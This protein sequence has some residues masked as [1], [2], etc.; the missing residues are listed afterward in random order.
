MRLSATAVALLCLA[1]TAGLAA[2]AQ[3]AQ[4]VDPAATSSAPATASSTASTWTV[5]WGVVEDLPVPADYGGDSRT[6][7]AVFRPSTGTWWIR[8]IRTVQYGRGGDIPVPADYNGDGKAEIAVVRWGGT[9]PDSPL[10]WYI[11]GVGAYSYGRGTDLPVPANYRGDRRAELAVVRP[12]QGIA[13]NTWYIRGA[14]PVVWGIGDDWEVPANYIGDSHADIAV[15]RRGRTHQDP[16]TWYVRGT[17]PV[18]WGYSWSDTVVDDYPVPANYIGDSH[19]D[20]AIWRRESTF[21]WAIRGL[22]RAIIW[23]QYGDVAVPGNYGGD[24]H[25]DFAVWRYSNGTWYIRVEPSLN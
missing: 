6:D 9:S 3:G 5:H 16:A 25:T 10:I 2:P 12:A 21:A 11:R 19:A 24:S 13:R 1:G 4:E 14:T 15:I 20:I 17:S 23:G 7:I 22:S 8:G 18:R